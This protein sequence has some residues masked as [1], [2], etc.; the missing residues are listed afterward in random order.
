MGLRFE[1]GRRPRPKTSDMKI[2]LAPIGSVHGQCLD[3][4]AGVLS[5]LFS[6]D[7][8]VTQSCPLPQGGF[9]EDR[10]QYDAAVVFRGL[11]A[12]APICKKEQRVLGI[13][14]ADVYAQGLD[15]VFGLT[16]P[17]TGYALIALTRLRPEFYNAAG[18]SA[19]FCERGVKEAV[20]EVGHSFGLAHCQQA[21]C[22]MHFSKTIA[23]TDRKDLRFCPACRQ[24]IPQK[25]SARKLPVFEAPA[26]TRRKFY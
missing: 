16:D 10:G 17:R 12:C 8:A 4:L 26:K 18:N 7:V 23:D 11:A 24:K 14:D 2:Y 5:R 1:S 9:D 20:H 25:I 3:Y 21:S 13:I 19:L 22:I 6:A 15:F